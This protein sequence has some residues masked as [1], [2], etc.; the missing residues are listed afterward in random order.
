MKWATRGQLRALGMSLRWGGL[1]R[2]DARLDWCERRVGR[3]LD[4][5]AEL[6]RAEARGLLVT[7]QE[8]PPQHDQHRHEPG[9]VGR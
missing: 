5:S 4:S 1:R 8:G 7:L 6:T 9:S 3:A 2:R